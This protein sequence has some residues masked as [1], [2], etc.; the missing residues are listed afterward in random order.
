MSRLQPSSSRLFPTS[1]LENTQVNDRRRRA[2]HFQLTSAIQFLEQQ[3]V[4]VA[5]QLDTEAAALF[6]MFEVAREFGLLAPKLP[7][8]WGGAGLSS[9][10]YQQLQTEM[11]TRSGA[12]T[13]LLTQHQS[14]ASF[15]LSSDNVAL[16]TSYLPAM[17][18]GEKRVGVGFS[19]LRRKTPPLTAQPVAGGYRLSGEVPWVTGAGLFE[20]FVGAA[21]L[22][23]GEAVFGLLPLVQTKALN[24]EL[25]VGEP[26]LMAGMA[27]TSTVSVHLNNWFLADAKT[28]GIRPVGWLSGR[29]LAN[30]LSPVG[31]IL[32]CAAGA[33][34]VL[35]EALERRQ[36]TL[37]IEEQLLAARMQLTDELETIEV[38]PKQDYE[39][40]I[41]LRGRAIALM[42]QSAQAA[43]VASG[44]AANSLHHPARRIYGEALVFSVSGQTN[45]GMISTLDA[46]TM[47]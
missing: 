46:I 16:K 41:S 45:S 28:V 35:S 42:T 9:S 39:A 3:V 13:F 1:P 31:M 24:G 20:A 40:K 11:A 2:D 27:A 7:Q 38:L 22:P 47:C 5:S 32:G 4:P 18:A 17:A 12:L 25:L 14:A 44:G 26:M 36:I 15:L 19:H 34:L 21:V 33:C 8:G 29:D 10:E 43:I 30:P 37:N 6:E 23:T